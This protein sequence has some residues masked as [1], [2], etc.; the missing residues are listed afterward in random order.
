MCIAKTRR[1]ARTISKTKITY[2][3][4]DWKKHRHLK[5]DEV[6]LA[7]EAKPK[8]K[9]LLYCVHCDK[10]KARSEFDDIMVARWT[11]HRDITKRATCKMCSAKLGKTTK[12]PKKIWQ[13]KTYRCRNSPL[14]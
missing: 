10:E 2:N 7:C 1:Q 12:A 5:R 14:I 6:C 3:A 13:Q 4:T 9:D 11:K 8:G